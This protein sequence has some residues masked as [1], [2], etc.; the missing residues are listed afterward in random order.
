MATGSVSCSVGAQPGHPGHPLSCSA[1]CSST[2]VLGLP[3]EVLTAGRW[4]GCHTSLKRDQL[5]EG[6]VSGQGGSPSRPPGCVAL[7]VGGR[8][9]SEFSVLRQSSQNGAVRPSPEAEL[10][11]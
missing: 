7:M 2:F 6:G 5:S 8:Q 9:A 11:C 4:G 3:Q 1:L 10:Q